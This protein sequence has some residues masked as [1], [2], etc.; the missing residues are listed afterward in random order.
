MVREKIDDKT[1]I[2]PEPAARSGLVG[3]LGLFGGHVIGACAHSH[4]PA[5]ADA[6]PDFHFHPQLDADANAFADRHGYAGPA[7]CHIYLGGDSDAYAGADCH[8]GPA[9]DQH[10]GSRSS[11][12]YANPGA[13]DSTA[14]YADTRICIC[15]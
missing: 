8:A 15:C 4:T 6:A 7:D 13:A 3:Q 11:D 14:C 5:D 12:G 2:V 9:A 10:T 1:E